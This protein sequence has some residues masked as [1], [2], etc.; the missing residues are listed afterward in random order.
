MELKPYELFALEDAATTGMHQ[1]TRPAYAS[2]DRIVSAG[3]L[4][5]HASQE[6]TLYPDRFVITEAGRAL[7]ESVAAPMGEW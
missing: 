5:T 4:A 2:L 6:R 7:Y 1:Q 3:L